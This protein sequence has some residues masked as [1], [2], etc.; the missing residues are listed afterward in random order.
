LKRNF[1][2]LALVTL[3][4]LSFCS[5]DAQQSKS[6]RIGWIAAGSAGS[7]TALDAFRAGM[8]G[9]GY[10]EGRNWTIDAR[11]G[12]GSTERLERLLAELVRSNPQVIVTQG[13][14]AV[15]VRRAVGA[16][17]VVFAFSGDPVE[18]G[19]VESFARPGGNVT[20]LSFLALDLV[21]K[22]MELLKETIPT[23]KRVAI[24]AN[25]QHH[26]EQSELHASQAAAKALGLALDYFQ[27]RP[28]LDPSDALAAIA[29]SR[30]EAV[31]VFP[32]ASLLSHSER[33]RRSPLK[34]VYRRFPVGPNLR[35]KE[36]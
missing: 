3:I 18:A 17:P 7:S 20:G 1:F 2:L 34:I 31:V 12:E 19:L 21:G 9:L 23:L 32:D 6:F 14:A 10:V 26:G 13:P 29:Q 16:I 25:P 30:S 27:R 15:L 22:R 8:R 36:T 28:A 5:V 24:L 33:L 11:W 4:L 35:K